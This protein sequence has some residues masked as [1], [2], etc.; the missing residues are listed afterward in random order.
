MD[1]RQEH[2]R[3]LRRPL[4]DGV[5]HPRRKNR[6]GERRVGRQHHRLALRAHRVQRI[7]RA[8]RDALIDR[9]VRVLMGILAATALASLAGCQSQPPSREQLAALDYRPPPQG[10]EKIVRDYLRTRLMEPDF[11]RVEFKAGPAPLYQKDT[12][13]RER[14]YGSV[15]RVMINYKASPRV[16]K[17]F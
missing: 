11:A 2:A 5:F 10:Y 17:G 16:H 6:R 8:V 1:Q 3:R 14:Q 7:G 4:S 9:P 15:V 12:V 13:L